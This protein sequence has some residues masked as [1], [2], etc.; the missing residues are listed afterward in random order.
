MFVSG[1]HLSVSLTV[2]VID[3]KILWWK[4]WSDLRPL[5][6]AVVIVIIKN[7][8]QQPDI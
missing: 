2:L 7:N 5:A 1:E 8:Q 6:L 4:Y 3:D